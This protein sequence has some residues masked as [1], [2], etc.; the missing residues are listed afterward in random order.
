MTT[1]QRESA[2]LRR[3]FRKSFPSAVRG[4]GVYVWDGDGKRYLD[5][6]GS[7]AVNFIGHGVSEIAAAMAEQAGKLEFVHTSQFTTAVA[8]EYAEELLAFA[9]E[10][11]RDGSV[12]FTSGGSESIETALK[13]ARQYHV[14]IGETQR[15]QVISRK[16]SYHGATFGA[17]SVSGNKKRREM[18][19]QMVKEFA[20]VGVPYCYR[21]AFDCTDGCFN[22]GQQYASEVEQAIEASQGEAA[23]FVFEPVSGATL[24]AVV[25]PPGYLEKVADVCRRH[26]VLLIADEVMTGMGRTGRNFAVDHWGVAPDILVTAK[27]LSSVYAPLGAVIASKKVVDAIAKGSGAF[28]HGFTYNA[29]PVS[30]AAGQ[31]VLRYLIAHGLVRAANSQ[32]SGTLAHA[33]RQALDGLLD[34]PVVGDVRGVGLL[35]GVEL[36]ADKKTKQPFAPE[37]NFAPRVGQAAAEQG[38]LVYPMQGSVDGVSGDHLLLA[39]PA[40]MSQEQASWAVDRLR[41]AIETAMLS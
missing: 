21:C 6:S 40:V 30:V 38:L 27:G 26:G 5:F 12:Y 13:L 1:V 18:Y 37:K 20:H 24:G 36:V 15:Y 19:L 28:L 33:L 16:Q 29:H 8:E 34:L 35:L 2:V 22:C 7:A 31:A 39:P 11:F 14:E 10:N 41:A 23:A 17:L 4:E 32:E 3:S 9:G 25:P